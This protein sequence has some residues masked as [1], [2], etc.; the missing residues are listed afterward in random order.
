MTRLLKIKVAESDD[1][2][3]ITLPFKG[4]K[5]VYQKIS[6][7]K[8]NSSAANDYV[9]R[10]RAKQLRKIRKKI[11]GSSKKDCRKQLAA[12]LKILSKKEQK[13]VLDEA[14]LQTS[15]VN[16]K[17]ACRIRSVLRISG[18]K[19]K[20]L[21]KA[22]RS[23]GVD[24]ASE[25]EIGMQMKKAILGKI[26]VDRVPVFLND[27]ERKQ[28][29]VILEPVV[30]IEDLDSF[31]CNLLDEYD[32]KGRLSWHNETIPEGEIWVKVGGDHG[33]GSFKVSLQIANMECPNS[34]DNTHMILNVECADSHKNLNIILAPLKKK[35]RQLEK[36]KW[37]NKKIKVFMFGDYK[38]QLDMFG[39]SQAASCHPCMWCTITKENMQDGETTRVGDHQERSLQSIKDDYKKFKDTGEGK[40][41]RAKDYNNV[42]NKPIWEIELDRVAPPYLHIFLG[43]IKRHDKILKAELLDLDRRIAIEFAKKGIPTILL[44]KMNINFKSTIERLQ[45]VMKHNPT[46]KNVLGFKDDFI[47]PVNSKVDFELRKHGI[48]RQKKHDG[49][50][51]GNHCAK[52]I[53][54]AV[55][56][57]VGACIEKE[58]RRHT[59]DKSLLSFANNTK[60]KFTK[61]NTLYANVHTLIGHS[62]PID[63]KEFPAI[64]AAIKE[65]MRFYREMFC[66]LQDYRVLPKQ[67]ILEDHCVVWMKKWGFGLG[68]HGE[69]GG[70]QIHHTMNGIKTSTW[71][72]RKKENRLRYEMMLQ[73]FKCSPVLQISARPKVAKK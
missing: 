18:R 32:N 16:A 5:Q 39:L 45:K 60:D 62:K 12:E 14:G 21:K 38:F 7:P 49:D 24:W 11:S 47:G 57:S 58:T 54:Q 29:R 3:T 72:I 2:K 68:L 65:Y 36:T 8:I 30:S 56:Q 6:V 15:T 17:L 48:V 4:G 42:I 13:A 37:R 41:Q 19:L 9:L 55:I 63:E 40:K 33:G 34:G 73:L 1:K 69:Q 44:P 61:M 22:L 10:M 51:N 46:L 67:H 64:E 50:L 26:R 53:T 43:I 35:L 70:E 31:V 23:V 25:K 27:T 28:E 71:G 66:Q 52:Y 59:T 20:Y